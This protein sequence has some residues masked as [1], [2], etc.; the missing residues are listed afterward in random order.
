MKVFL[1]QHVASLLPPLSFHVC[2]LLFFFPL[3][4]LFVSDG[5]C[6][7]HPLLGVKKKKRVV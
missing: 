5:V 6:L 3:S 4:M 7:K 1:G 2:L